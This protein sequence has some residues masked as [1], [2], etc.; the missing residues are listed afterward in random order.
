MARKKSREEK[1]YDVLL[2]NVREVSKLRAG[3]EFIWHFLSLCDPYSD[4]FTGQTETTLYNA[5]KRAVGVQLLQLLDDAD[6]SLYPRLLLEKRKIDLEGGQNGPTNNPS[7]TG[8]DGADIESDTGTVPS[9][10]N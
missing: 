9:S 2:A 8:I 10:N 4:G 1:E 3:K 5:G 6:L 7:D